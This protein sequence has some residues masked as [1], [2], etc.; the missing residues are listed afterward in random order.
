MQAT[1]NRSGVVRSPLRIRNCDP[2]SSSTRS[3]RVAT[4]TATTAQCSSGVVS[5]PVI[6][7][8][9]RELRV[10]TPATGGLRGRTSE[11]ALMDDLVAAVRRGES[12]SLVLKGEAGIGKTALLEYLIA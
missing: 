4:L 3:E 11:C 5:A 7:P 9:W 12:R 1:L 8:E 6:T 10:S 2:T